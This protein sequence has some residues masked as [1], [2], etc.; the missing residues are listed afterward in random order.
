M[1]EELRVVPTEPTLSWRELGLSRTRR[2]GATTPPGSQSYDVLGGG[3]RVGLL[4]FGGQPELARMACVDGAWRLENRRQFGW[5][6][7]IESS[8]GQHV[9]SYSGRRWL[10]GGTI[11]LADGAQVALQP[12]LTGRWK[13]RTRSDRQ[14]FVEIRKSDNGPMAL[15][16]RSFP[17]EITKASVVI[18][19]ACAVLLLEWTV[20]HVRSVGF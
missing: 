9:G 13:L 12:S 14:S 10:P 17:A 19:T 15:T 1:G 5:E 7:L 4:D 8:D 6:F 11:F 16:I 18:L 2:M 3:G 20:A